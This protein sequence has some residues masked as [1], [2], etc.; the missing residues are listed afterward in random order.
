[1]QPTAHQRPWKAVPIETVL[2]ENVEVYGATSRAQRR[3]W[4]SA[5]ATAYDRLTANG[6]PLPR[7][8]AAMG[9]LRLHRCWPDVTGAVS[10]LRH[11]DPP[12]RIRDAGWDRAEAPLRYLRA[13]VRSAKGD[14]IWEKRWSVSGG[15]GV[16]VVARLDVAPTAW[17]LQQP[18]LHTVN[19]SVVIDDERTT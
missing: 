15:S 6:G 2:S 19:C 17:D 4:H 3:R 5:K 18:A 12:H 7:H 13:R 10:K 9:R 16:A 8:A 1:M 14:A 11:R